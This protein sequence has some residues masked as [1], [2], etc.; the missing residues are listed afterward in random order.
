MT[1]RLAAVLLPGVVALGGCAAAGGAAAPAPSSVGTSVVGTSAAGTSPG[2]VEPHDYSFA[3]TSSCGE[4]AFLGDYRVT[5]VRGAIA[6][7]AWRDPGDGRWTAVEEAL[8]AEVP[9]LGEM[10]ADAR[11]ASGDPAAGEVL[12]ESDP[13]D[14][15]PTEISVDPIADAIDDEFCYVVT[16]Y[17]PGG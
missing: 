15:H 11:A 13:A 12:V 8:L 9:S 2:W 16:D 14:G 1:R 3:V 7:A 17:R 4:R 10:V 6:S 5:V